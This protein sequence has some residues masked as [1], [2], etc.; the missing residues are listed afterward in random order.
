M[1]DRSYRRIFITGAS[2]GIGQALAEAYAGPGV[3]LGLV[4]RRAERLTALVERFAKLGC[5]A[6]PFAANVGDAA[7]MRQ[8]AMTFCEEAGGVDL[9]IANAGINRPDRSLDGDPAGAAETIQVNVNG[10]LHTLLPLVPAMA[11]Q[12]HGHLVAIGSVAGFRGLPGNAAYC[13]SKAAVKTLM[14][15][16]RPVFRRRGIRVTTICPGYVESELTAKN[17]TPMPFLMPVDK[18]ARLIQRAIAR[19]AST[20]VFPW[21]MRLLVPLLVRV[22]DRFFPVF[23]RNS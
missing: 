3:T 23:E 18:A 19:G 13:A 12:G 14:D 16:Y 17:K 21:Q 22:P 7:Q 10:V 4:A 1:P 6:M 11:A 8:V 9:A 15:A 2:A 5:T 20:Y